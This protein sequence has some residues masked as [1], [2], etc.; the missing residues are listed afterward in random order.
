MTLFPWADVGVIV[1]LFT[2]FV[3]LLLFPLAQKAVKAQIGIKVI[4]PDLKKIKED[5]K[6]NQ[7]KQAEETLK[8][9]R[10]HDINPFSS[11]GL[12]LIQ[13]PI[14]FGLYFIFARGGFPT[15]DTTIL[16]S[17]VTAPDSVMMT[18]FGFVDITGRSIIL[19]LLVGITQYIQTRLT[20]PTITAERGK[21]LKDDIAHSM[22]VQMR[23]VLPIVVT[24]VAYTLSS[25]IALYWTTSNIF[26]ILQEVV[27]RK[28][29][30]G[31]PKDPQ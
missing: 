20:L 16:Y 30:Y 4:E 19:S 18:L 26:T 7:Q 5:H 31:V 8:L 17:F 1:I 11:I 22:Q 12:I 10:E 24:V 14:I 23:Y 2:I 9:Y 25:I 3:K 28:K 27:I 21:S 13:L 29:I 15:I 6:G